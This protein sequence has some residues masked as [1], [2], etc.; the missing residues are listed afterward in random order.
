M[1][2]TFFTSD[3]H[4]CHSKDF[5]YAPRGF[6][7]V[8][9]HNEAIVKN[10]NS[11]VGDDDVVYILGDLMLNDNETATKYFN[12]LRG[13][14]ILVRGNHDTEERWN[15]IYPNLRGVIYQ[16]TAIYVSLNGYHFY[17]SHFPAITASH[18]S[19]P[20]KKKWINLCGHSH[21][22][23]KF[24]DWD[25]GLIYHCELDAH[26]NKPV[27]VEEI[28]ADIEAREGKINVK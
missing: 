3:L 19:K 2:R 20:L 11:I 6:T 27:S 23:D 4:L 26:D 8:I 28:I 15:N 9:E 13:Y 25:K 24:A 7:N 1:S 17:L 21:I 18:E 5:L 16:E 10:W 12:Q 22:Q 14:K